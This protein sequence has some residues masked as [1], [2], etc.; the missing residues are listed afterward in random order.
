MS[1]GNI[2]SVTDLQA[3]Q[4]FYIAQA[5]ME[6]YMEQLQNDTDW[7]SPPAVK[8]DEVFG[9]G[10]FSVSYDNED[11]DLIDIMATGKVVGWD[12]NNVQRIITQQVERSD[13]G[14]TFADFVM[15]F[16]GG[17][18]TAIDRNQTITGDIFIS[19]DL[20]IGRNCTINDDVLATGSISVG[21]G[22]N[23][24]G[25]TIENASFP[26]AQPTLSTTYYDNLIS[27]AS[28]Q[29]SGNVTYSNDSVS[30]T[31][32]VNGNVLIKNLLSG[33]GTIV[34]SGSIDIDK[35]AVIS[36]D[37]SFIC[38]GTLL[39]EKNVTIGKNVMLY[40]SSLVDINDGVVLG[41]G[42]GTG[43]GVIVLSPIE[44]VLDQNVTLVGLVFGAE[45]DVDNVNFTLTG[46]LCGDILSELDR[47]AVLTLDS[48]KVDFGSIEGFNAG[49]GTTIIISSWQESL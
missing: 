44:V 8:T 27:T 24:Y 30:G 17:G 4:A 20:D 37:I 38:A 32:Y 48:T 45:I 34:A 10:M 42:A 35:N 26:A 41:T 47:G 40:S 43:E 33:S 21:S 29:P 36:D 18:T 28:L 9:A 23:I 7:S 16:G 1:G 12:G 5:G 3:Q 22:T 2:S 39:T 13:G 46:N 14:V 6:W 15:F 25:S 19:G 11:T 49:T 31:V